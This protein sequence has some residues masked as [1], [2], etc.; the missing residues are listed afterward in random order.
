MQVT[1]SML[2]KQK[3]RKRSRSWSRRLATLAGNVVLVL[4]VA[5]AVAIMSAAILTR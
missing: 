2:P 5:Y 4:G 1:Q 3:T